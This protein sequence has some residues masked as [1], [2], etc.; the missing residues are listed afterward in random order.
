[1]KKASFCGIILMCVMGAVLASCGDDKSDDSPTT[2]S[3]NPSSV[4]LYYEGTQQL[5]ASGATSWSSENEFVA[6]VDSKGLVTAN[7]VGSTNILVSNG[8]SM[9]KCA[10]TV[11]PKYNCYDTPLLNWGAS[12]SAISAAE[13]HTKGS[14][15]SSDYLYYEYTNGTS[16]ALV[17]YIF[18]NNALNGINVIASKSDYTPIGYFLLERYQPIYKDDNDNYYLIDAMD[19][20]LA[21]NVIVWGLTT[22]S[23]S[24]YTMVTYFKYNPNSNALRR[25]FSQDIEI[26]NEV[27]SI[28]GE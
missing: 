20:N 15:S 22:I 18:K 8:N 12:K 9:G 14:S 2:L 24:K 21:Q 5:S 1:M 16:V 28:L 23:S 7:H 19:T 10:V 11:I 26:P 3:V 17:Q 4:N 27:L 6:K 25:A 13:T